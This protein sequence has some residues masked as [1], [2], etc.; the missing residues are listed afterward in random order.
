[1]IRFRRLLKSF[2]Y[3]VKGFKKSF[4]EEQNLRI[5]TVIGFL[6]ILLGIYFNITRMEWAMLVFIIGLVI[7]MELANSAV[8]RISDIL[9]PRID[10]YVKEIKDIAAATVMASSVTA[11]IIGIIIFYPYFFK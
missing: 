5:Q 2:Q 8:E 6:T 10:K 9:K 1:M 11:I 7:I 3:A 4:K